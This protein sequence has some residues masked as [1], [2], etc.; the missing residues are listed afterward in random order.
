MCSDKCRID[1][2]LLVSSLPGKALRR[3]V[4]SRGL[5]SDSTCVLKADPGKYRIVGECL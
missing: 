1:E 5:S 4:A 3:L 2:C